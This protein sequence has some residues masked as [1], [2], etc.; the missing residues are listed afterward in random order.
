MANSIYHIHLVI[1]I[2][3]VMNV[4]VRYQNGWIQDIIF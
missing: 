2:G 4:F 1:A 3:E